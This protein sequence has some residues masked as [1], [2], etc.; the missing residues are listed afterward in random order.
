LLKKLSNFGEDKV[1]RQIEPIAA[2]YNAS[3]FRKIRIAD[4]VD[5]SKV[6]WDLSSYAM[7]AH[8]DFVVADHDH[9][10]HFAIEFD[11]PGHSTKNDLKKDKI[12]R[13]E[14]LALFRVNLPTS[15]R[16]IGQLS[17]VSYL[18]HLWF[19]GLQ[20]EKMR[21]EGEVS[22]DEPFMISGFLK[23]DAKHIFDSE[24]DLL[25]PARERI[26]AYCNKKSIGRGAISHLSVGE[27]L[28]R[29]SF[30]EYV[31]FCGF[32][33]GTTKLYGRSTVTLKIPSFGRLQDIQFSSPE[34]G[35]FCTA[36]AIYDLLDE[37]KLFH[38]APGHVIRQR[39]EVENEIKD[40][41][42]QGFSVVLALSC[43]SDDELVRFAS[44]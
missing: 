44:N 11:G 19:L 18:V 4:V 20:F 7:K 39:D 31:A 8:F 5:V 41:R 3:V 36:S 9:V 6:Q 33:V 38:I 26:N 28:M 10:P 14:D 15:Q 35:Q 30:G 16:Q 22:F 43:N 21:T 17:F 42:Q 40:L 23:P 29:N 27:I 25:G 32:P 1:Y 13:D 37:L 34:L 12:C 2:R 24:F